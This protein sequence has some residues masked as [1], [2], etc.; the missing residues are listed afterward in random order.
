MLLSGVTERR[1]PAVGEPPARG[2]SGVRAAGVPRFD[3]TAV[4]RFINTSVLLNGPTVSGGL[5]GLHADK[6]CLG[7]APIGRVVPFPL[8][9]LSV[10][11]S[12]T[13]GSVLWKHSA[14][15]TIR[16]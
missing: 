14:R 12:M 9:A 15:S 11:I 3:S 5:R 10:L 8:L 2:L 13:S 1:A 6:I 7:G 4:W 16:V